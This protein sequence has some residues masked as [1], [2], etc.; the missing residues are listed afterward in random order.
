MTEQQIRVQQKA[1][2][3]LFRHFGKFSSWE[4]CQIAVKEIT[5]LI[6]QGEDVYASVTETGETRYL[7]PHNETSND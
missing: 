2:K 7:P 1:A 3:I 6:D 5:D 4:Q